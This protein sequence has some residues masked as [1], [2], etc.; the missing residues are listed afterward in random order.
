MY[1]LCFVY[2]LLTVVEPWSEGNVTMLHIERKESDQ[3]LAKGRRNCNTIPS[4][5]SPVVN[6][7]YEIIERIEAFS[8]A[9]CKEKS[10]LS[11]S[12]KLIICCSKGKVYHLTVQ[13]NSKSHPIVINVYSDYWFHIKCK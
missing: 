3:Q 1:T 8:S 10:I 6:C 9:K 13:E 4:Y 5:I 11:G 2:Y 7:G 12:M